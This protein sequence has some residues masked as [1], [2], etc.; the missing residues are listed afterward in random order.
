M[1]TLVDQPVTAH[2]RDGK[3]HVMMESGLEIGFPMRGNP[4][5]EGKAHPQLDNIEISPFG[6]HW[7][8]LDEDLSLKGILAGDYGAKKRKTPPQR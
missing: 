7:P 2:H 5:L 3:I 6:P 1:S 4:R 8:D